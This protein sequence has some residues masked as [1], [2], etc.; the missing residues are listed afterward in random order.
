MTYAILIILALCLSFM[1]R[2]LYINNEYHKIHEERHKMPKSYQDLIV[3][4]D[5]DRVKHYVLHNSDSL[6]VSE[7]G[8]SKEKKIEIDFS[9]IKDGNLLL[10]EGF[11]YIRIKRSS[12]NEIQ[13][14]LEKIYMTYNR[15]PTFHSIS[16][17][18]NESKIENRYY[19]KID[20]LQDWYFWSYDNSEHGHDNF[21]EIEWLIKY[22]EAESFFK[23]RRQ[24]Q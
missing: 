1:L 8:D 2:I 3:N 7:T 14:I 22:R 4:G 16:Y 10:D 18:P 17:F 19:K 24:F 6:F 13:I 12:E 11:Q 15:T 21:L 23:R 9:N 5:L 20:K